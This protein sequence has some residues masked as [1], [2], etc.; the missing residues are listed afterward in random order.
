MNNTNLNRYETTA[1]KNV[2]KQFESIRPEIVKCR[3][4]S[5]LT[6]DFLIHA[7]ALAKAIHQKY[8]YK[9][10]KIDHI[11]KIFDSLGITLHIDQNFIQSDKKST[12]DSCTITFLEGEISIS[13]K[14]STI[15]LSNNRSLYYS[16]NYLQDNSVFC[17]FY[18]LAI[19]ILFYD[20]LETEGSMTFYCEESEENIYEGIAKCVTLLLFYINYDYGY[21]VKKYPYTCFKNGQIVKELIWSKLY[22]KSTMLF[23]LMVVLNILSTI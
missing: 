21:R 12:S 19:V 3:E 14:Y 8:N 10:T 11:K 23:R 17:Y 4:Y 13:I 16:Y 9:I 20:K 15:D 5:E 6:D 18:A 22:R 1:L 2:A 7:Y